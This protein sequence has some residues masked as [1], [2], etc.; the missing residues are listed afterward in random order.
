L[1]PTDPV[2]GKPY[3]YEVVDGK[4]RL[5]GAAPADRASDPSFNRVLVIAVQKP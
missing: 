3:R 5:R 4:A 2:S 1:I